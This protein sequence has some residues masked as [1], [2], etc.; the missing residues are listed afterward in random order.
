MRAI[1][2]WIDE[3]TGL[4]TSIHNF[5]N[6][7]LARGVGYPHVFGSLALFLFLIQM[8]TGILLMTYYSPAPDHAYETIEFI[9]H[10]LPFGGFVRGLH[11]WTAT[12]MMAA[13]GLHLLQVFLWGA[14]KK[15]RQIIW[16]LG[17]LLLVV[18]LGF[19]FTG[20]LLPWDQ[21][22]YW[23]TVVGTNIAGAVPFVGDAIRTLLRGGPNVGAVTLTRFFAIHVAILPAL[24]IA[25]MGFHV[26]QVRRKGIT[27]PGHDVGE[28]AS[29]VYTQ[30]FW[31][32]Q[33]LK[34]AIV[35]F[36]VFGLL[37]IVALKFGAPIEPL[38]N[39]A[40]TSYIPRPE[41]YFL[42]LFELLKYFPGN[43]EFVGAVLLP[44]IGIVLLAIY[45]YLDK[46]PARKL[47]RRKYAATLCAVTF[48]FV[49]WLGVRAIITTPKPQQLTAQQEQGLKV[50]M[51]QRCTAC[52]KVNGD[53]GN[54]GPDLAQAG[55]H[56]TSD[57]LTALLKNPAKFQKRSIMP[58]TDLPPEKLT[59]LVAYLM[60]LDSRSTLPEEPPVGPKKPETHFQESW[61]INHKFEV[62]KDPAQ[63]KTCHQF[64]FC[65]T[66]HR[67]RKPDSHLNNWLKFHFGTAM[68]K[69]E[70]CQVC[71]DKK[72]C[73]TCHDKLLHTKDWLKIKHAVVGKTNKETCMQCH[74]TNFCNACHQGAAKPESHTA[75]WRST[76]PSIAV[77]KTAQCAICHGKNPCASCHGLSLPHPRRWKV[78]HGQ[79]AKMDPRV[80]SKCHDSNFCSSCHGL[81]IPHRSD[82][83]VKHR[84][85]AIADSQI[86]AKCHGEGKRDICKNCH[87]KPPPFHMADWNKK[88]MVMGKKNPTLC[89]LCHGNN[90]CMS[91]HKTP[92]PHADDWAAQHKNVKGVSREKGSFCYK[93]H[94]PSYCKMCHT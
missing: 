8:A 94:E 35:A 73:N 76:H 32:H 31:P 81:V 42:W 12:G 84:K 43:L 47:S 48:A 59:A 60:A 25:L 86:C 57:R 16:V 90:S 87:T 41:W 19:S 14:Y 30:Y 36:F 1:L 11:H 91:C 7:P 34:D 40:D 63:C 37:S 77:G 24:I 64:N 62:R 27:P 6:E 61:Y 74:E 39:P 79:T 10:K 55:G 83:S 75:R 5:M 93:C 92:M 70:Y 89:E 4:I 22:A 44:T 69:P 66:C 53:G 65:Q 13:V 56:W 21:K 82:W 28:E 49:S 54:A 38:A 80:C 72:F 51:D 46:N 78:T 20:Y 9:T 29:A 68:E 3:Q 45:P 67:N 71:H 85:A 15:P 26:L 52:H 23:A 88:H 18:T 50:F 2:R 17:V 58:A 33:I